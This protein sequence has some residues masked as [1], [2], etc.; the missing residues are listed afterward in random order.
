[1]PPIRPLG[2]TAWSILVPRFMNKDVIRSEAK[3]HLEGIERRKEVLRFAQDD[4][5]QFPS[6]HLKVNSVVWLFGRVNSIC[7]TSMCLIWNAALQ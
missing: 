4:N 2:M 5:R 6:V 7:T 3:D 1:M